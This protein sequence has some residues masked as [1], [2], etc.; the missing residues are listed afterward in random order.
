MTYL[1]PVPGN[2]EARIIC[3]VVSIGRRLG[4]TTAEIR[5]VKTGALCIFGEHDKVN[6]DGD[7][8]KI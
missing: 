3:D 2:S 8:P 6:T 4:L 1:R 7:V 5:S